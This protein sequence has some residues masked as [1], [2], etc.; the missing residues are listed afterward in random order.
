M[1]SSLGMNAPRKHESASY[2]FSFAYFAFSLLTFGFVAG[3]LWIIVAGLF[4]E[5][6]DWS[7]PF[8]VTCM[9]GSTEQ[10]I[11]EAERTRRW[12]YGLNIIVWPCLIALAFFAERWL[13]KQT[14]K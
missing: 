9:L 14:A 3:L 11:A 7:S 8:S 13:S 4:F 5:R 10:E 12:A 1:L 2:P 6:V